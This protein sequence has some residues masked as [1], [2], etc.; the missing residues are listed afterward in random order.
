MSERRTPTS[1]PAVPGVATFRTHPAFPSQLVGARD[2]Q[3]YLPPRYDGES[4]RYPVLYMQDG[5]NIFDPGAVGKEWEMDETAD[6]LVRDGKIQPL[7]IVGI[8]NTKERRDEYTPTY[9]EWERPDGTV[10]KGGGKADVYGRYLIEELKPFI[11]RTYRTQTD[12][13][14]TALG[15]SSLGGLVSLWLALEHPQV[16]GGALAVSPTVW[17]D[18]N[19]ILTKIAALPG[20]LPIRVWVDIGG[21]EGKEA[22]SGV[23][24]LREALINKGWKLGV[25]FEYFE[26]AD[27]QHDEISW[28]SRVERMLTFLD[29]RSKP[30]AVE[31]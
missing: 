17:W 22:V 7:I 31:R 1:P 29:G 30:S 23:R 3:V 13:A 26:Q 12:A 21:L 8:P 28:G 2:I 27:G 16:F 19:V 24:R 25:D 6:A 11:D 15:G 20:P 4:R 14:G 18:N 5:Q 10:V 9:V